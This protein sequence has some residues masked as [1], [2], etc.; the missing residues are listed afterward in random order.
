MDNFKPDFLF[1]SV[2]RYCLNCSGQS[3]D[4]ETRLPAVKRMEVLFYPMLPDLKKKAMLF[5]G[6]FRK[7]PTLRPFILLIRATCGWTEVRSSDAIVLTGKGQ[8]TRRKPYPTASFFTT[9]PT[10]TGLE[11]NPGLRGERPA[12]NRLTHGTAV[13]CWSHLTNT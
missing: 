6:R 7:F 10:W 2:D 12:T 9:N 1:E 3:R 13:R 5:W 4:E 8:S 11:K